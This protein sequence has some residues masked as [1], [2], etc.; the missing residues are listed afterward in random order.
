M[1]LI[2]IFNIVLKIINNILSFLAKTLLSFEKNI[3]KYIV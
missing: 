3:K 1:E 2:K